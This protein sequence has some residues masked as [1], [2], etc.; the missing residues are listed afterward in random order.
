MG[1]PVVTLAGANAMGRGA[2]SI[3][4]NIGHPDLI[5]DTPDA[6][7]SKAIGLARDLPRCAELRRNLRRSLQ[8]SPIMNAPQFAA[9]LESA[10]RLA[11]RT[12]CQQPL[13]L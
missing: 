9:D 6:Y 2:G 8:S 3:L 12:W 5:A 13:G 10:Y 11:W 7:V 1:I 4:T